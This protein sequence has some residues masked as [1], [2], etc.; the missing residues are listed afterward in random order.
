M[1][2][3][4]TFTASLLILMVGCASTVRVDTTAFETTP[5]DPPVPDVPVSG[6]QQIIREPIQVNPCD[7]TQRDLTAD[8]LS[9]QYLCSHDKRRAAL[10]TYNDGG[11]YL[12][13]RNVRPLLAE[14][15][16]FDRKVV[17]P[18][19]NPSSSNEMVQYHIVTPS[20][21]QH[22][23]KVPSRP[24]VKSVTKKSVLKIPFDANQEVLNQEGIDQ[25]LSLIPAV[26][27]ARR[28]TLLGVYEQAEIDAVAKIDTAPQKRERFSV[29]RALSIRKLWEQG[30]VDLSKIMIIHHRD[31][32]AGRYVEV[33][34]HD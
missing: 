12:Q 6:I 26:K 2:R 22:T 29:G 23:D 20:V 9:R 19:A 8:W 11:H 31:H 25:S 16:A 28:I 21:K 27:D 32:R 1:L 34:L 4:V 18:A 30:G 5:S 15:S 3:H 7:R 33:V 24:S 13:H 17:A 10:Q 14:N